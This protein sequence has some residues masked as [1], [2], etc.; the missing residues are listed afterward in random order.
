MTVP[1]LIN[2]VIV[3]LGAAYTAI[4]LATGGE[5]SPL[6]APLSVVGLMQYVVLE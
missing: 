5:P 3:L 6:T 2:A 4:N 1:K